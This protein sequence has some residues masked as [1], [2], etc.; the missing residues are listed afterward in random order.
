MTIANLAEKNII[1]DTTMSK[2]IYLLN[3]QDWLVHQLARHINCEPE[4]IL[5]HC[6]KLKQLGIAL[7]INNETIQ[8]QQ[9]AD[10]LHHGLIG[11]YLADY[12][13]VYHETYQQVESTN[14][15]IKQQKYAK[16]P[17]IIIAE[18]QSNGVGRQKK[19]WFSPFGKGICCSIRFPLNN[20]IHQY[21]PISMVAATSLLKAI[22]CYG[23]M[24]EFQ[25]KWPNDLMYNNKKCAGILVENISRDN[26]SDDVIIGIGIN[27]HAI[28]KNL[29]QSISADFI[30]LDNICHEFIDR[31][32]LCGLLIQQLIHDLQ[33]LENN[34][35]DW[36][37]FW[38]QHNYLSGKKVT[39]SQGHS[40][41]TG[42]VL[43]VND[44]G[45]IILRLQD[46]TQQTV[47]SGSICHIEDSATTIS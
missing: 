31:N 4:V 47:V 39:I 2:M 5:N 37:E 11:N 23:V 26:K 28:A 10:L 27:V 14:T 1:L 7:A 29:A 18:E 33:L 22:Q 12:P 41:I 40:N 15:L 9:A 20:K 38:Q 42:E 32:R 43:K 34:T 25:F 45:E 17:S 8:L 21:A 35:L 24:E 46:G 30:E 6:Q 36:Y 44:R 13:E 3:Q 16:N 19:S